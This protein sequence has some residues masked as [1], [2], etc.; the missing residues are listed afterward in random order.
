MGIFD[1]LK[2]GNQ[3]QRL[4]D[5]AKLFIICRDAISQLNRA[6]KP[7]SEKGKYEAIMLNAISALKMYKRNY[8]EKYKLVEGEFFVVLLDNASEY[9][10]T[11]DVATL[12]KFISQ[13]L[14]FYSKEI[15]QIFGENIQEELPANCYT[16]IYISPMQNFSEPDFNVTEIMMFFM[17]L[18]NMT[19]WVIEKSSTV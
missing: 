9:G 6:Y 17:G 5:G 1:F 14:N 18:S 15:S 19:T 4:S 10:I 16:A 2:S 7:P 11:Q 8:P 13:R 3:Y 12:K